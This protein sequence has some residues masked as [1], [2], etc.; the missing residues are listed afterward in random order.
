MQPVQQ[1]TAAQSAQAAQDAMRIS[2]VVEDLT[3]RLR[4]AQEA[5]NQFEGKVS[6]L[7]AALATERS[8]ATARMDNYKKELVALK[9][10]ETRLRTELSQ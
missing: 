6:K 5:K 4:K 10:T 3:A 1:A 7:S 9:E 2:A 8:A